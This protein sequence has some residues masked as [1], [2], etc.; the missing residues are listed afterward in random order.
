VKN[1]VSLTIPWRFG[2]RVEDADAWLRAPEVLHVFVDFRSPDTPAAQWHRIMTVTAAWLEKHAGDSRLGGVWPALF[3]VP[4]GT[5]AEVE[6]SITSQLEV[7]WP[8]LIRYA[9]LLPPN[10]EPGDL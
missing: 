3:I 1:P 2:D 10:Y 9:T 4:N 8:L 7:S 6:A 5:R